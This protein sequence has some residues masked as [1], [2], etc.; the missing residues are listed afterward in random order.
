MHCYN[1]P[2]RATLV[3][4][5]VGLTGCG[6]APPTEPGLDDLFSRTEARIEMRDGTHLFT[7]VLTPRNSGTEPLPFLLSRTPYGTDG[8]GGTGGILYG[9]QELIKEGYIFAFQDIRGRYESEGEFV[10]NRAA[11][12]VRDETC[13]DEASDTYDTVEWLLANVPNNNGRVGQLGISYPGYLVNATAYGPH[14]AIKALSPQATMGDGWMGD[15]FFHQGAFRLSYGLEYAWQMEASMD[16]SVVPAPGRFDT[17]DWYRSFSTLGELAA[18]VGANDWPTWRKFVEHPTYDDVWK[19][20]A[21]PLSLTRAPVP[22]LTVGGWWDQEDMWGPSHTYQAMETNDGSGFNHIV[23]GPWKHGQWFSDSGDSLGIVPWGSATSDTYRREIEAPWFAFHLKDK[24]DGR[25]SEATMFDSGAQTW[26]QFDHWPPAE[27]KTTS[28]Y[29]REDGSL[30]F[31][32]PAG[33]GADAFVSDPDHPVPYRHR[34]IEWTYD[35]RGSGWGPWMTE[36]QRFVDGRPDV[37]V[38]QT[39][40]LTTEV[41]LAGAVVARLFASTT[42][43]DADWVVKLIDVYPDSISGRPWLGGHE[44]MVTGEIMRGRYWKGF[45]VATPLPANTPTAFTVD[46]HTQAYTFKPGHRIMVQV[47]STWFPVHDRN[48]QTFVPNIFLAQAEDYQAQ[49]HTVHRSGRLPSHLEL[50]LIVA[51]R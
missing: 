32:A 45:E 5:L 42:G 2:L 16:G 4:A 7:V 41:T 6:Q 35:S 49:T 33:N 14:P 24:G 22:T 38:Y 47:Q 8:W 46:M 1:F 31:E 18:A 23:M 37:L 30:S 39:E 48:P 43:T 27:A 15:D 26:K 12:E 20:L 40:P 17:Y 34:P 13:M 21:T 36:D 28:L 51:E 19:S 44:L 50:D 29:F 25:F 11:C 10:M 3:L 9:F